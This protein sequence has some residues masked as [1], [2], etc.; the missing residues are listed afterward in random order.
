MARL[1]ASFLVLAAALLGAG[2]SL[3]AP[4]TGDPAE[5]RL[6]PLPMPTA[7]VPALVAVTPPQGSWP[8]ET[9]HNRPLPK[10]RPASTPAV[11]APLSAPAGFIAGS[12]GGTVRTEDRSPARADQRIETRPETRPETRDEPKPEPRAVAKPPEAR[13]AE[14]KPVVAR[15]PPPPPPPS[16]DHRRWTITEVN[17]RSAPARNAPRLDLLD[18]GTQVDIVG[19]PENGWVRIARNGRVLG[20]ILTEFL[21]NHPPRSR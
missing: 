6:T 5:A 21:V 4:R 3:A 2:P 1:A 9:G 17:I 18:G 15:T 13:P 16:S 10:L 11:A 19:A 14:T 20:F 7:V 12:V 8:G